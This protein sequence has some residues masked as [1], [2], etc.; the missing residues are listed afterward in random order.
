MKNRIEKKQN[1]ILKKIPEKSLL[2]LKK[3]SVVE[4]RKKG[5]ILFE[6][7]GD[8]EMI[9]FVLDGYVSLFRSSRYGEEKILFVCGPGE[10][11]NEVVLQKERSSAAARALTDVT[12]ME[13]PCNDFK[14]LCRTDFDLV[15]AVFESLSRKT[16]RLAHQAG[17]SNGTYPLE[18]HLASKLWKLA[19][20][21]GIDTEEGKE[22]NFEV[23]VTFLAN[24]LGAKRES[25]SR[26]VSKMKKDG[27]ISHE[28]RKLVVLD[29][30]KLY[31]SFSIHYH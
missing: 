27:Y 26:A 2:A 28:G 17:N 4:K 8:T 1:G 20:D 15:I 11:L 30:E 5:D 16:R 19:R 3:I 9:Y 18:K 25:V 29:L 6:E 22:I 14:E 12:L 13:A 24:M 10:M 23:T 7:R 31:N 21:Y